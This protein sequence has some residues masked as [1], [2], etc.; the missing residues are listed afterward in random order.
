MRK[1]NRR[2]RWS[3]RQMWR[4]W[5]AGLAGLGLV[6]VVSA[7]AP[8]AATP[9][10]Q[11]PQAQPPAEAAPAAPAN[12][13]PLDRPLALLAEA[14]KAFAD[15]KDYSCTLVKQERIGGRLQP[16]NVVTLMVRN[17][18]FSVYMK[19]H[20]PRGQVGQEACYVEGKNDGKMRAKSPGVLGAVGFVSID[21]DDPRARK[22]SN[23]LITEAG[24][25]NLLGRYE[26]SWPAAKKFNKS[27]VSIGE[28][29]YAKRRCVRVETTLA[30]PNADVSPHYRGVVYFDKQTKLP[31]RVECYDW[32]R[33]GGPAGG[34]LVEVYSYVNLKLNPGLPDS[35]FE[36]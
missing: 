9:V 7:P 1:R 8:T 21:V 35:V 34:E 6:W 27:K 22:T 11:E 10:P 14:R 23:H 2:P 29:E 20:E 26:K 13:H 15:V 28:Y 25:G 33:R 18:P 32:P 31:I 3:A 4:A 30:E 17:E 19:W 16:N 5:L 36:K 24:L 12:A